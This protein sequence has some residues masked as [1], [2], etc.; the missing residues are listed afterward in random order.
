LADKL[1]PMKLVLVYMQAMVGKKTYFKL[2]LLP[3]DKTDKLFEYV[4][5][6]LK[7]SEDI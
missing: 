3:G 4:K 5:E 1:S 2:E 6:K 7:I